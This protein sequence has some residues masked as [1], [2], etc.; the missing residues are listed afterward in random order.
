MIRTL[1]NQKEDER[2]R[3]AAAETLGHSR[4]AM[5]RAPLLRALEDSKTELHF[6]AAYGLG[7]VGTG[8]EIPA[9]QRILNDESLLHGYGTV[10][11]EARKAIEL[12]RSR[13]QQ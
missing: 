13:D 6:W 7:H 11:E 5:A 9:L 10:A 1:E 3:G 4:E 12:I 2:V 8:R